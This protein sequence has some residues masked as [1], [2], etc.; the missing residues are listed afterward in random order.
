MRKRKRNGENRRKKKGRKAG[1]KGRM[2][3]EKE[4]RKLKKGTKR[5]R[6]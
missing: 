5:E 3:L 4:N 1:G 2:K 6:K